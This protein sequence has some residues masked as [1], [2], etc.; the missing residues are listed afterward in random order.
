MGVFI[1]TRSDG[2]LFNLDRL[3]ANTITRELCIRELLFAE[4]AAIVAHTHQ[5]QTSKRFVT[6]LNKLQP[7]LDLK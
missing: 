5:R 6:T 1:R 4:D 7:Y 2:Q 3:R